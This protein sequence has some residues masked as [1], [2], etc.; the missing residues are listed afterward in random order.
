MSD[1]KKADTQRLMQLIVK[2]SKVTSLAMQSMKSA[3]AGDLSSAREL[4][5][6]AKAKGVEAHNIQTEM[7]QL[8][9]KG[10]ASSPTLLAVHA[11]DHFMNS[12]LLLEMVGIV[13]EQQTQMKALQERVIK[14][15]QVGET[16]E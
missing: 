5:Y 16:H 9:I 7:I 8:E 10:E 2:S 12:H 14:L 11:Q 4:L 15:E 3:L 6:E 13:V 1:T